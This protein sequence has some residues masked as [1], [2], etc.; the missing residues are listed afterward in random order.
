MTTQRATAIHHI[1]IQTGHFDEAVAFYTDIIGAELC[2]RRPFKRRQ[3]AWLKVG[4]VMLE[5]G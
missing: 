2:E 4:N 5:R 3:M 1:A